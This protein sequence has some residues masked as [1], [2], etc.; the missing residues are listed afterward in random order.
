M[1]VLCGVKGSLDELHNGDQ[2]CSEL[3]KGPAKRVVQ[4][5]VTTCDEFRTAQ[6]T[7]HKHQRKVDR[8]TKNH[9]SVAAMVVSCSIAEDQA[10]TH[11]GTGTNPLWAVKVHE[12]HELKVC[13]VLLF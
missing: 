13:C 1:C 6:A 12:S 5:I 8:I 3:A 10:F 4:S 11:A 7:E 9:A 2:Q